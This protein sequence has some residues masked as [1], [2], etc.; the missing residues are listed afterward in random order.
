MRLFLTA[1]G[2]IWLS[3]CN[4][5]L[6]EKAIVLPPVAKKVPKEF[7]EF[8]NTRVD[9]YFWM[10]DRADS[11][12]VKHLQA[13]NEYA[14]TMLKHT[15][16]LQK[17]LYDELVARIEQQYET[18]P[19]KKNGYW[20]FARYGAGKQYPAYFRKKDSLSAPEEPTIDTTSPCLISRSTPF[21]ISSPLNLFVMLVALI[22]FTSNI[23]S[24]ALR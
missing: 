1:L 20:Y 18:V 6:S 4:N 21:S 13:E 17:K 2:L 22:M 12:V 24:K 7:K 5:S 15:G 8:E 16:E 23:S 3:S 10:N 19:A 14:E 9:E 11:D